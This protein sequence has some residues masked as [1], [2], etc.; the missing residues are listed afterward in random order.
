MRGLQ[1]AFWPTAVQVSQHQPVVS[2]AAVADALTALPCAVGL[3]GD[4]VCEPG[5]A[6]GHVCRPMSVRLFMVAG[7]DGETTGHVSVR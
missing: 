2:G 6:S 7:L 1:R 3:R 5:L 4:L